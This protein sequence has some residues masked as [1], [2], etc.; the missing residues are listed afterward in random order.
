M[1][2]IA[3][4]KGITPYAW[5]HAAAKR[6]IKDKRITCAADP[7]AGKTHA[8]FLAACVNKTQTV[9]VISPAKRVA[10][11]WACV[12]SQW[13]FNAA[14]VGGPGEGGRSLAEAIGKHL[15]PASEHDPRV[16]VLPW[17]RMQRKADYPHV[18]GDFAA[19]GTPVV[20]LLIVDESHYAQGAEATARGKSSLGWY[21]KRHRKGHKGLRHYAR[22]II[23][24]T[25][26]PTTSKPQ[27]IRAQLLFAGLD[28][29]RSTDLYNRFAYE[30][31]WWGGRREYN[32]GAKRELWVT[33]DEP[34]PG[35]ED[36]MR[37]GVMVVDPRELAAQLPAHRRVLLRDFDAG[38][39]VP[40]ELQAWAGAQESARDGKIPM[41]ED[42]ADIRREATE[43]RLNDIADYAV[44]WH[45][46]AREHRMLVVWCMYQESAEKVATGVQHAIAK[47]TPKGNHPANVE[48]IHGGLPDRSRAAR[49]TRATS[50]QTRVLVVTHAS[51]GTGVDGLQHWSNHALVV[52][53][54]WT[55]GEAQQSE[56]RL[57][58]TGQTMPVQTDWIC[59]G[60]EAAI[61]RGIGYKAEAIGKMMEGAERVGV[62]TR[63]TK[64]VSPQKQN[65][66]R[67]TGAPVASEMPKD[68]IDWGEL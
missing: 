16:V 67:G 42:I 28:A 45:H 24:L 40:A 37:R 1:Y 20:D 29:D 15:K 30:Q 36:L 47:V 68:F 60:C 8:A 2:P 38:G 12:A 33:D 35:H 64:H 25:G 7:G 3:I 52:E 19:G 43:A 53:A 58:R 26:T 27:L 51:C 49:M 50:G 5:Q 65:M 22:R 4:P 34:A 41:L 62:N 55:P 13:G 48:F 6:I 59:A 66:P 18:L 54:P 46:E 32:W 56:G 57:F 23:A 44:Q 9:I 11:Q 21:D 17:S 63:K 61:I 10:D 14:L 31:K 39:G